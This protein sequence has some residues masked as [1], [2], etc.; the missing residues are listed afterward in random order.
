MSARRA[1]GDWVWLPEYAGFLVADRP[2]RAK[3]LGDGFF[4]WC[5]YHCGDDECR[6]WVTLE[7]ED[8]ELLYH[9]SE[10]GMH[11]EERGALLA[12]RKTV[13]ARKRKEPKP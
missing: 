12:A 13:R 8:G 11:D 1:Q 7:R 10:C 2:Q 3:I 4:D 5:V 9:V 6:E